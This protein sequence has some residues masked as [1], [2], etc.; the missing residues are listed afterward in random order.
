MIPALARS[1]NALAVEITTRFE[2]EEPLAGFYLSSFLPVGQYCYDGSINE[3]CSKIK[4]YEGKY[5]G[6]YMGGAHDYFTLKSCVV[7]G[8]VVK[9]ETLLN[10]DYGTD[11]FKF[12]TQIT[13]CQ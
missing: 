5:F 4:D 9:L 12:N 10:D 6:E 3:V 2:N 7:E 13:K 1:F 11:N 8:D